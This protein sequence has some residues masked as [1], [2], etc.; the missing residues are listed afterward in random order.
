MRISVISQGTLEGVKQYFFH[1]L[2]Q[3]RSI[4]IH[5]KLREVVKIVRRWK[6]QGSIGKVRRNYNV[7]TCVCVR[8]FV[9]MKHKCCFGF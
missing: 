9:Q 1:C 3:E 6:T 4:H 2:D 8:L 5:P 7:R